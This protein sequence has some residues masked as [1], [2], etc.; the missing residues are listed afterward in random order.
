MLPSKDRGGDT[1]GKKPAREPCSGERRGNAAIFAVHVE[2]T[3]RG[4]GNGHCGYRSGRERESEGGSESD[5]EPGD[6]ELEGRKE[7]EGAHLLME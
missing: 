5:A 3:R 4:L 6:A 2:E 7:K 1:V